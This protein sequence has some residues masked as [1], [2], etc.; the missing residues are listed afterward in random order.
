M[1]VG[2]VLVLTLTGACGGTD[3]AETTAPTTVS[4]TS[5]PEIVTND[6]G[7]EIAGYRVTS[8]EPTETG[9]PVPPELDGV[10]GYR[11]AR[12]GAEVAVGVQ[13][14]LPES[15]SP[16]DASLKL[17]LGEVSGGGAP[18]EIAIG[19]QKGFQVTGPDGR[20]YIGNIL[21]DGSLNVVRGTDK[22]AMVEMLVA[23]TAATSSVQ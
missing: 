13:G 3:T 10:T 2:S 18:V 9:L 20:I 15:E 6:S 14:L 1:V 22:D 16:N 7:F 17:V 11:Y 12:D 23:L 5:A 19:E 8:L 4:P 21:E